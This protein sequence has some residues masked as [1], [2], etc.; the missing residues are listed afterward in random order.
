MDTDDLD[1]PAPKPGT[2]GLGTR[3][4]DELSI[5]ALQDYIAQLKAEVARAE[6]A[7]GA[8]QSARAGAEAFFK[9]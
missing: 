9:S 3:D 2:H 7:I 6:T 8:K 1:P 5:E 4:L